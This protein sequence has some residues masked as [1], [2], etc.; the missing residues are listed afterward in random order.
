MCGGVVEASEEGDV[1]DAEA[2]RQSENDEVH[3]EAGEDDDPAVA[4]VD[5]GLR[6]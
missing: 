1:D 5:V 2:S 6:S 4:A 3:E